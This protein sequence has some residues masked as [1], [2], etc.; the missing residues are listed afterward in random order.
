[1][2]QTLGIFHYVLHLFKKKKTRTGNRN[3]AKGFYFE[4]EEA[5]SKTCPK[6]TPKRK[7]FTIDIR[8][9]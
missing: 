4:T 7:G 8:T 5:S 1:M 3:I 9:L 2:S 6:I